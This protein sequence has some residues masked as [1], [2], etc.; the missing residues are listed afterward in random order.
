MDRMGYQ[1][2]T[3]HSLVVLVVNDED[4]ML[5]F[6][7]CVLEDKGFE[8]IT[9]HDSVEALH[10]G[11]CFPGPIDLLLTDVQMRIFQNGMELASCFAVLRPETML[12]LTSGFPL[13]EGSNEE[14]KAWNFLPKPFSQWQ[15]SD[16]VENLIDVHSQAV[17]WTYF[18]AV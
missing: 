9:A 2:D 18:A 10:L 6:V 17:D 15:L 12:L 1:R 13:P 3:D 16:S 5:D 14:E 7:R 8:V 4:E 11:A